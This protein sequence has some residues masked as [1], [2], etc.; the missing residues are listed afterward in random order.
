MPVPKH[1]EWRID[2]IHELIEVK[3][4]EVEIVDFTDNE[5][6]DIIAEICTT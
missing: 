6:D 3:W 2:M 4:G 5:I 1:E